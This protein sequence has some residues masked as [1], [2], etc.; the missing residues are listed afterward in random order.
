MSL[1]VLSPGEMT[2]STFEVA[3]YS[4]WAKASDSNELKLRSVCWSSHTLQEVITSDVQMPVWDMSSQGGG[5]QL[6]V[7]LHG[8]HQA[9]HSAVGLVEGE[10]K[11]PDG[12]KGLGRVCVRRLAQESSQLRHLLVCLSHCLYQ[13]L[14]LLPGAHLHRRGC[15]RLLPDQLEGGAPS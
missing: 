10:G 1:S 15:S 4:K 5:G 12:A 2:G 8:C 13:G 9:S 7:V 3:K 14:L 6:S 11:S